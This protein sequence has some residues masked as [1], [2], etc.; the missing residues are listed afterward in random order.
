MNSGIYCIENKINNKKYYGSSIDIHRRWL[1]HINEL[2]RN[3]HTNKHLQQSWN[4]YGKDNFE[5][6]VELRVYPQYLLFIEQIYLDNNV[7]GYN[8][9]KNA[10]SLLGM[11]HSEETKRK[12]GKANTGRKLSD[13][14]KQ[15]LSIA[16][17]GKKM[18]E[19][20]RLRMIGRKIPRDIVEKAARSRT[21]S[22]RSLET[23]KKMSAWQIGRKMSKESILQGVATRE[24]NRLKKI[25]VNT[26]G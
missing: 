21:G 1:E 8:I 26:L 23:R 12:I 17:L 13:E 6:K 19:E 24:R 3:V 15:K 9:R 5:F 25:R 7:G 10:K 22:K 16:H 18:A 14:H 11:K 2:N 20:V 4:K